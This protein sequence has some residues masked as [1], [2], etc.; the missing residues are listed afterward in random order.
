MEYLVPKLE[1][2]T[3]IPKAL[4]THNVQQYF[5]VSEG[6]KQC[7][8]KPKFEAINLKSGKESKGWILDHNYLTKNNI[9]RTSRRR[10]GIILF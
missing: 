7:Y 4:L 5:S 2:K 9:C 8:N 3:K 1:K 10:K 6:G